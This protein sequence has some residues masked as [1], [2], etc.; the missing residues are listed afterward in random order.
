SFS[1]V[2][3]LATWFVTGLLLL[4]ALQK[5]I[6]NLG[7][8]ILP[9]SALTLVMQQLLT[10]EHVLSTGQSQEL[11]I[12][13]LFSILAYSLLGLAAVQALVLSF[14]ERQLHN[15]HPGGLIRALPPMETMENWLFQMLVAGLLLQSV[16]L[17][18]GVFYLEDM[19]TQHM[20]H[21]TVLS[22][23]AW[24][25]FAILLWG[26]WRHGWRGRTAVRWTLSG[27]VTLLL[28]YFGSKYV[29]EIILSR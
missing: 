3:S 22:I 18:T 29:L 28:A 9:L 14:Q 4:S 1:N 12:H 7:L 8:V 6:E 5:P 17:L 2:A 16:S 21:K 19:F 27:F 23:A 13:I 25:V 26:H 24:L 15:R 11:G 20:V 10:S